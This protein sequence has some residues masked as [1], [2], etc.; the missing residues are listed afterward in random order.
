MWT[1]LEYFITNASSYGAD[2]DFMILFITYLCGA[3]Y[4]LS[5]VIFFYFIFRYSRKRHPKAL[6][7]TGETEAEK[8]WIKIPH[9]LILICD[10][11][12]LYYAIS[13]WYDVKQDMPIEKDMQK[14]RIVAQQWAWTFVHPG[15]DKRLDTEDDIVTIDKLHIKKGIVYHFELQSK[16]VVHSLGIPVFRLT[17]DIIP[18]R[19][20]SG[21][22]KAT[23][24]G[25]WDIQCREICGIGHGLMPARIV[26]E[27]EEDHL[28]WIETQTHFGPYSLDTL[29]STN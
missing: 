13:I 3:W 16:D 7:V 14:I 12:I 26:I 10:V 8:K 5:N 2:I 23:K 27:S 17:Q 22:F 4:I 28:A 15:A 21:W 25:E 20:I 9:K 18:G 11:F 1:W 19:T 24:T 29:A 6:Y